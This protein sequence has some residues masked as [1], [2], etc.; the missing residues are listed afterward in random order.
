MLN[1]LKAGCDK[2][3]NDSLLEL[4]HSWADV[5]KNE[6]KNNVD[7]VNN[8]VKQLSSSMLVLKNEV[9][10]V[11]DKVQ[12]TLDIEERAANVIVYRLQESNNTNFEENRKEDYDNVMN[13][14]GTTSN[15]KIYQYLY[16]IF[17]R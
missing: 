4:K 2:K 11:K 12:A 1:E 5:V 8:E 16:L 13:I 3:I 10:G 14:F 9:V 6:L 7:M 15:G 17:Y